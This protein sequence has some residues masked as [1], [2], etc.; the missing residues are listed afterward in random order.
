MVRRG[1]AEELHRRAIT[2]LR[3]GEIAALRWRN[4]DFKAGSFAVVESGEQTAGGVRY[5]EPKSGRARLVSLSPTV[6][7]N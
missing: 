1:R 4:V 6:I 5:K 7:D 2:G 3:R